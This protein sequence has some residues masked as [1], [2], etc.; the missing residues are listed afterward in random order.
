LSKQRKSSAE[1]E[2][3]LGIY[4]A[5]RRSMGD[6]EEVEPTLFQRAKFHVEIFL[7]DIGGHIGTNCEAS[8]VGKS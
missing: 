8:V 6:D 5:A 4:Q 1:L 7:C 3:Y 2:K